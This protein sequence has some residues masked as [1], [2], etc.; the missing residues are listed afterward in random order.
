MT[1]RV[2]EPPAALVTLEEVKTFLRISDPDADSVIAS[3]IVAAQAEFDGP[4]G[5]VGRCFGEQKL[6]WSTGALGDEVHVPYPELMSVSLI[7]CY[8]DGEWQ[9]VADTTYEMDDA[10]FIRPIE[11]AAWPPMTAARVLYVAG[12]VAGDPRREQIKTAI[13]FH[14]K[15]HFDDG[16]HSDRLRDVIATLLAPLRVFS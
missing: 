5:W 2:I 6:E 13:F 4:T 9:A 14:V 10:G 16:D 11:G 3:L 8:R 1:V 15:I 7:Q 12:M